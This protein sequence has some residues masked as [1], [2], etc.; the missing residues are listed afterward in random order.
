MRGG[1]GGGVAASCMDD[2]GIFYRQATN[3]VS[4]MHLWF[5]VHQETEQ[6]VHLCVSLRASTNYKTA[7]TQDNLRS[8]CTL[9]LAQSLRPSSSMTFSTLSFRSECVV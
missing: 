9:V 8:P 4:T 7:L 5:G 6:S 3:L 1:G 2:D